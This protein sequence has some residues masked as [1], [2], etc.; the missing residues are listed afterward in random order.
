MAAAL[1]P[2]RYASR[3]DDLDGWW[4]RARFAWATRP[5]ASQTLP[6]TAKP[7]PIVLLVMDDACTRA[8]PEPTIL[9]GPRMAGALE[10]V[11][12]DG[13]RVVALDWTQTTALSDIVP[14]GKSARQDA[15][16]ELFATYDLR[17]ADALRRVPRVVMAAE[18][19]GSKQGGQF[20]K[21]TADL[22]YSRPFRPGQNELEEQPLGYVELNSR[23][24][25]VATQ[26]PLILKSHA[27]DN[28]RPLS[29]EATSF[30]A[31]IV[32]QARDA[33]WTAPS[34]RSL[35]FVSQ[36]TAGR[37]T[38]QVLG[39]LEQ[40]PLG[41]DGKL[42]INYALSQREGERSSY[43]TGAFRTLSMADVAGGRFRPGTFR[44]AIVL[45]GATFAGSNDFHYVPLPEPGSWAAPGLMAGVEI[46]AH[47]VRTLLQSEPIREPDA[48]ARWA[49]AWALSLACLAFGALLSWGRSI[50]ATALLAVLYGA[51]SLQAFEAQSLALPLTVPLGG[52]FLA[53]LLMAGYRIVAEEGQRQAILRLWGRYQHPRIV[54][55][56]LHNPDAR[57]GNGREMQ[58]TVLFADLESFTKTVE[59]L[60]P[61]DTI[62]TLNRYLS[63]MQ[64]CVEEFD[65]IVDKY[66]G[67]GLLAQWGAPYLWSAEEQRHIPPIEHHA[68]AAARACQAMLD[69]AAELA[70]TL[71]DDGG[72]GSGSDEKTF[73]L[74]LTLHSGPA[75]A[76]HIGDARLGSEGRMEYTIIGDTVN[77]CSRLQE[78]AKSLGANFL[79]SQSTLEGTRD[80]VKI[81]RTAQV[82]IRGRDQPLQV[83]EILGVHAEKPAS[84]SR[85]TRVPKADQSAQWQLPTNSPTAP[86]ADEAG[87]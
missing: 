13:A 25:I 19:Q 26:A 39:R 84:A 22:L 48:G 3:A 82:E 49:L 50:G 44:D 31:R 42:L 17:L 10:R 20:I 65:G 28:T 86:Q 68:E 30:A 6:K 37:S 56:L 27:Q 58:V 38:T 40:V 64:E 77:V 83:F 9:W 69:R 59:H 57:G 76:G 36:G 33:R 87:T 8:W 54:E 7:I 63:L 75:I 67:D 21:P 80:A 41:E 55:H 34:A 78:S 32:E 79:I 12:R 45:V 52:M 46:Q 62:R 60:T 24:A 66:L 15:A 16:R 2:L 1:W 81:G 35:Q 4:L 18:F 5:T 51:S 53:V 73:G 29:I 47:I 11:A 43:T 72:H 85:H 61:A 14:V 71:A 23:T 74:R 70:R